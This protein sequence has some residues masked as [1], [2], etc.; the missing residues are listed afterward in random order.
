MRSG[1]SCRDW[2]RTIFLRGPD[3][4]YTMSTKGRMLE[5][6]RVIMAGRAAEEACSL[7]R[8]K[9]D[10]PVSARTV[11]TCFG[12]ASHALHLFLQITVVLLLSLPSEVFSFG[13]C[14]P[15]SKSSESRFQ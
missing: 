4:D 11:P 14:Y 6:L 10:S 15:C 3:E 1:A 2:T 13:L 9:I 7:F 5:R 8:S 12:V